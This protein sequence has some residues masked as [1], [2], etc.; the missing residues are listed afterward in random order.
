VSYVDE[1][2]EHIKAALPDLDSKIRYASL[3]MPLS[4]LSME[5]TVHLKAIHFKLLRFWEELSRKQLEKLA[6]LSDCKYSHGVSL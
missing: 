5:E 3:G 1:Q 2:M 6:V 4:S